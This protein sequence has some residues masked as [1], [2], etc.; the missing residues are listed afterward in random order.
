[1]YYS[2]EPNFG[3]IKRYM[4]KESKEMEV[5]IDSSFEAKRFYDFYENQGWQTSGKNVRGQA[6][7]LVRHWLKAIT[8]T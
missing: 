3:T 1:M 6:K 7:A 2:N 4:A 5:E 8:A